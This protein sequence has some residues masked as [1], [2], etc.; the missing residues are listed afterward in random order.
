LLLA[1]GLIPDLLT[2][3]LGLELTPDL[4]LYAFFKTEAFCDAEHHGDDGDDRE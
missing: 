4:L 1:L 2:L 3:G